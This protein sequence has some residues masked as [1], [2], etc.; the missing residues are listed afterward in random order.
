MF[1][2]GRSQKNAQPKGAHYRMSIAHLALVVVEVDRRSLRLPVRAANLNPLASDQ[3][4]LPQCRIPNL[5]QEMARFPAPPSYTCVRM[6]ENRAKSA[7]LRHFLERPGSASGSSC[8]ATCHF[9]AMRSDL[10]FA[11]AARRETLWPRRPRIGHI[12]CP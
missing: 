11:R 9:I 4:M 3:P 1:Y 10:S 8:S 2:R 12:D 7:T 6:L 5:E